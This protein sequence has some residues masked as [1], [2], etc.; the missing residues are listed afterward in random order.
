[1]INPCWSFTIINLYCQNE[2]GAEEHVNYNV[3]D[4]LALIIRPSK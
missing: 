3:D 2:L 4:T 1:M